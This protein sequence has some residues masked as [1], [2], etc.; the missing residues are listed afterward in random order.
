MLPDTPRLIL[1]KENE[2][3]N[4]FVSRIKVIKK[5][6]S[7]LYSKMEDH[8]W[9]NELAKAVAIFTKKTKYNISKIWH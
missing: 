4:G 1:S 2:V 7:K 8:L 6:S 9:D 3:P 5:R